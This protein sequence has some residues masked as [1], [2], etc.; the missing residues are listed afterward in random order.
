MTTQAHWF[1]ENTGKAW[2]EKFFLFY[3]PVWMAVMGVVMGTGL[4]ANHLDEWGFMAVGWGLFLPLL[5]MP[6][7][8]SPEGGPWHQTYWFKANLYMAVF[9]FFGSYFGSEYFFDMLGMVYDYPMIN[10]NLDSALVGSGE[11]RVPLL[12]YPLAHVYFI[13]YHTT[14]VL[15]LRRIT[16]AGIPFKTLLWPVLILVVG[17]FWAWAETK[18]MANPWIKSQ[19]YYKDMP[20][21]LQFGS[22]LYAAYFVT[23]F[24]I[25][26]FLDENPKARWNLWVVTAA[27]LSA[28]MLTLYLL[29]FAAHC[30]GRIY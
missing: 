24:P 29:D 2:T 9:S 16:T 28:S 26:Y 21:M 14:A 23:S 15:V 7:L 17:Y 25:Y 6:A 12:M 5:V 10:I 11:Q 22:L 8:M 13:T 1:A 19:F 20:R 4:A 30:V 3:S 27:A 18:A